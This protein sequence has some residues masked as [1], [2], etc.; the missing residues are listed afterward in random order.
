MVL[1]VDN[2]AAIKVARN[3]GVTARNKHFEDSIH[4]FRHLV[5]HLVVV[6]TYVT[7]K[8]QKADGFTKTLEPTPYLTWRDFLIEHVR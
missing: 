2:Q 6:P 5:D 4:F 8:H 3:M 1:C 7:T